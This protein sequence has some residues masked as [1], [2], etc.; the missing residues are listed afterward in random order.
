MQS[1][2]KLLAVIVFAFGILDAGGALAFG[3]HGWGGGGWHGGWGGGGWRGG[4]YGGWG[5]GYP[6]GV[7]PYG[8]GYGYGYDYGYPPPQE[9]GVSPYCATKTRI[10]MLRK[11]REIGSGC[12]CRGARGMISGGPPAQ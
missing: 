2:A 12:S 4:W 10:C 11:P 5:W 3:G 8:Y 6:Y 9:P 7:W 1:V